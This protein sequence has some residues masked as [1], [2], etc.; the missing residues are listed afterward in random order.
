[1]FISG[2]SARA[3]VASDWD[4]NARSDMHPNADRLAVLFRGL[5]KQIST[6]RFVDKL[7]VQKIA[8]LAQIQGIDLGYDFEWYLRGPYCKQV[9]EDARAAAESDLEEHQDMDAEQIAEFA[10]YIKPHTEDAEWLEIAASLV[11]LKRNHYGDHELDSVYGYLLDDLTYG[12]KN[13]PASRVYEVLE[14]IRQQKWI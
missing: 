8:Y 2:G 3:S 11:Y 1:M 9:S 12:Y 5:D 13:F 14:S 6:A 4:R 7:E 10:S